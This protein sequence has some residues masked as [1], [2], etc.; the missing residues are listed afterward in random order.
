MAVNNTRKG[1]SRGRIGW[2]LFALV[3]YLLVKHF[4]GEHEDP[5]SKTEPASIIEVSDDDGAG[6]DTLPSG[7]YAQTA[8]R[9]DWPPMRA[10]NAD[11]AASG[12]PA[13]TAN[14]YV[15]LDG[16]GSMHRVDCSG[17]KPKIEV[18][19]AA[20]SRFVQSVPAQANLGLAVFD[21]AGLSERVP[22]GIGNRDAFRKALQKVEVHGGTPLKSAIE[23]GYGKLT[24]QARQQL[25]YG[26]YHLVLVTDGYPDPASED[27]ADAVNTLLSHSPVVLHTI[28]FCIGE[29]HVLN[30]PGR[31]YYT[32]ADSPE[33]LN[34][35]LGNV[36]AEAPAFDVSDFQDQTAKP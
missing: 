33:Q 24:T 4:R 8:T 7:I 3:A 11:A 15:V 1:K 10:R 36:L 12:V 17:G 28:G 35:G 16:S 19:V 20:L 31:V 9:D 21:D 25:G 2:A 30:Q 32:A 26:D 22:L 18:A 34:E 14:Y 29:E 13:A 6:S 5:K 23:L 27:P